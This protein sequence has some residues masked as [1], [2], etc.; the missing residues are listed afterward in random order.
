MLPVIDQPFE[1]AMMPI[2]DHDCH[3]REDFIVNLKLY[4]SDFVYP[5]DEL[6]YEKRVKPLFVKENKRE[7]KDSDEVH[8][9]M[10]KDN[11]TQFWNF[12]QK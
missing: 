12:D 3:A 5:F 11:F 1:H 9:L 2:P 7:P 6:V 4:L 8:K 10:M